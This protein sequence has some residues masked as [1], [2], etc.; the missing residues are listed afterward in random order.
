[1][2]FWQK[3]KPAGEAADVAAAETPAPLAAAETP[4]IAAQP[5]PVASQ[6]AAAE[7]TP[8]HPVTEA[9]KL[10]V[11]FCQEWMHKLEAREEYNI[12]HI[13]WHLQDGKYIGQYT[14][15][16][17]DHTCQVKDGNGPKATTVGKILYREMLYKK[18]GVTKEQAAT[19]RPQVIEITET[20]EIFRYG[21][22][23]WT[24]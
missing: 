10:F 1:M 5:S 21:K 9:D 12:K 2:P 11:D 13:D 8:S 23:K 19:A 4:G 15:Y 6:A 7:P 16:S 3:W 14:G 20:T 18:E 17:E 22:G 24:W